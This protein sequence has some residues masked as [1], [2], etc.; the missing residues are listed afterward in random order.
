[1]T[2]K[3]KEL[4]DTRDWSTAYADGGMDRT[5]LSDEILKSMQS[6]IDY[7]LVE[8]ALPYI[9]GCKPVVKAS[10]W[11]AW[12]LGLK[13]T[14]PYLKAA[15]LNSDVIGHYWAHNSVAVYGAIAGCTREDADDTKSTG[16][17][18]TLS[19]FDGHGSWGGSA[20][21]AVPAS[22]R[23]TEV[24]LSETGA[25]CIKDAA[26]GAVYML[27]S[28][29]AKNVLPQLVPTHIPLLLINGS[30][31]LAYGYNVSWLP[32]NPSEAIKACI[33][34]IDNPKC[35]YKDIKKIMPGPDFPSGGIVID[36]NEDGLDSAYETGFG[37]V[38]VCARFTITQGNRGK[39]MI[40][41]YQGPYKVPHSSTDNSSNN[42]AMVNCLITFAKEHPEYGITDVKNLSDYDNECFIEVSIRSGIDPY[43]VASAIM[44]KSSK[45]H[46]NET[47][48]YRQSV[49]LGDF[50]ESEEADATGIENV[51]KLTNPTPKDVGMIEYI[52]AFIDFRVACNTNLGKYERNKALEQKHL[53]DGM[54]TALIDIDKVI[55]IVRK[56]NNK[57]TARKSLMKQFKLDEIQADYILAIPLSRLTRSDRIQLEGNSKELA[58]RIK[59][60][61]KMLSSRKNLVA[62]VKRQL[63]EELEKYNLPRRTTIINS[64]GKIIAKAHTDKGDKLEETKNIVAAIFNET[65][66]AS[67]SVLGTQQKELT[68]MSGTTDI[69][70][71]TK[72]EISSVSD[73]SVLMSIKNIDV[74]DTILII[75][76]D[77]DSTRLKGYEISK[78]PTI[79]GK[80]SVGI[81]KYD[82]E[83]PI[84]IAMIT[85]D[86]KVKVLDATTLTKN[87]DCNVMKL[88]PGIKLLSARPV[89]DI[90][91]FVFITNT[92]N[93]LKFPVN[94]VNAQGRTSTGVAG[95]KLVKD[96][97][98]IAGFVANPEDILVTNTGQS[99]K[100]TLLSEYPPKGRGTQGVRCHK[101]LK[102][103]TELIG[104]YIGNAPKRSDKK[105]L[106]KLSGRDASGQKESGLNKIIFSEQD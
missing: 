20:P 98:V 24:R 101:F 37:N 99:I 48:S 38:S 9:D 62:E 71:N 54:L 83:S 12:K 106:P 100:A 68:M 43:V 49:V 39:H 40:N 2:R 16:C 79:I 80:K 66:R 36:R 64:K 5:D 73:N 90:S 104:A 76:E 70:L 63:E 72:G 1:M 96:A 55:A 86:G 34:R 41:I 6:Y 82:E 15:T 21:E 87:P 105:P 26:N 30:D 22:D 75:F 81:A 14:H 84:N 31:G 57:E 59:Q 52:D 61:D 53:I 91:E 4:K 18:V 50:V 51:L 28:F 13:P 7:T 85:S 74:N 56:S 32:H 95:I 29:D 25:S 35:N 67:E 3:K 33:Y 8:R 17:G 42:K 94:S 69:F 102:G 89:T 44:N 19:I 97:K 78:I 65:P 60:L 103:E 10:L 88:S 93:L 47:V 23:Y 45:T 27:P 46:L 58:A 11:A 77:G 92:A